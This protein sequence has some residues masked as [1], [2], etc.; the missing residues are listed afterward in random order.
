MPHIYLYLYLYLYR[1]PVRRR[2]AWDTST[3]AQSLALG[4]W[5]NGAY[6][7]ESILPR[8][9]HRRAS[10]FL[11]DGMRKELGVLARDIPPS[12]PLQPAWASM[13]RTILIL[14]LRVWVMYPGREACCQKVSVQCGSDERH[15]IR[16]KHSDAGTGSDRVKADYGGRGRWWLT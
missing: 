6:A 9:A 16:A 15:G 11:D 1:V 8:M 12:P 13:M 2:G 4:D 7:G 10:R 14:R 3:P 5:R